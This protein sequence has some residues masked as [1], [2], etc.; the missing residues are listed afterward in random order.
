M[1]RRILYYLL[2]MNV[3]WAGSYAATKTLMAV[4]PFY[5]VTSLRYFVAAV[6]LLIAA[7][8]FY[9]LKMPLR[10][11]VRCAVIGVCTFTL[12]PLLMYSG[13]DLARSSDAA[14]L[15]A[16]EPLLVTFGAYLYLRERI[17]RRTTAA[18]FLAFGGAIL[19]SE[20]W[21]TT[22]AVNPLGTLLILGGVFFETSYSV[23]GKELLIR[24]APLKVTA[25]T[26]ACGC[27]VNL[28]GVSVMGYW[29]L[30][31]RLS[32]GNWLL[33]VGYLSLVCTLI[34]YTVWFVALRQHLAANVAITIFAQPV[35]GILV[36]WLFVSETPTAW[37][38]IGTAVILLA[39]ALALVR[40]AA[41]AILAK[42][43]AEKPTPPPV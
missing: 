35:V 32:V 20:F 36:G 22:S 15:T 21:S 6:P 41:T 27:L 1:N 11:L 7:W 17:S 5:L 28:I 29:P 31:E 39:V 26:I 13:V 14:I 30:V 3:V 2:L 19:L 16:A 34:G 24:H 9:G 40:P 23:I 37:Q 12:T 33:L 25:V 18:L 38:L 8:Y 10:D 43:A 42:A 4:A